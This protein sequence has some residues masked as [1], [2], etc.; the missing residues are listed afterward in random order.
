MPTHAIRLRILAGLLLSAAFL[1]VPAA[2][3]SAK[4]VRK[5]ELCGARAARPSPGRATS[6]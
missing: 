1:L 5:A 3:A 6:S 4:A 2:A